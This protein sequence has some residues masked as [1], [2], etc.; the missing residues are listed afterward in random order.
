MSI[1]IKKQ[2]CDFW[3]IVECTCK[4]N[5]SSMEDASTLLSPFQNN[6]ASP[7]S[8]LLGVFDGHAGGLCSNYLSQTLPAELKKQTKLQ[9]SSQLQQQDKAVNLP[10]N[11]LVTEVF[12]QTD[13]QW[14]VQAKRKS[15]ED[16]S[17]ALCVV[18]DGA[19]LMVA[20]C[21][22]S[23]A[24]LHQAG[25]TMVLT[26]DHI[27]DDKEEKQRIM[28]LGGSVIGGRLQGKLGVSR[29]FGNFEFKESKYLSADPEINQYTVQSDAEFLVV[30]CDGL[31]EH[32]SNEEIISFMK[33]RISSNTLEIVVKELVEEALDRGTQDNITV[34][35]VKFNKAYS[36]L[37]KKNRKALSKSQKLSPVTSRKGTSSLKTSGKTKINPS[38]I[39]V[40]EPSLSRTKKDNPL[41]T[42]G[43]H[44]VTSNSLPMD[45]GALFQLPSLLGDKKLHHKSSKSPSPQLSRASLVDLPED[46]S[47]KSHQGLKSSLFGRTLTKSS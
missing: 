44:P 40:S 14:L 41:R 6:N 10:S 20:N 26:R 4:G 25:Q 9:I 29:A 11:E 43:K 33:A 19:D 36:K 32:F 15:I 30:G 5:R 1:Q 22:D 2:N 31:F 8:L 42:A 12:Q 34:F 16:G 39:S 47:P 18:L 3:D 46:K 23:R 17:T 35:V 21:G 13:R 38:P 7:A 37:L 45:P 24:L 28:K 27:P